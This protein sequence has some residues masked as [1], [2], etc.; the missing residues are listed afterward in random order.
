MNKK[1][2][3]A[4]PLVGKY[5][6]VL[7][8]KECVYQ[9]WVAEKVTEE[10]YLVQYFDWLFGEANI[11]KLARLE[12]MSDWQFYESAEQMNDWYKHTKGEKL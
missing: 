10:I 11:S 1:T 6:H 4:P 2:T 3:A 7:K 9:G 5:F 8:G 12:D